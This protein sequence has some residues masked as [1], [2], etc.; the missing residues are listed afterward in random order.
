M[1]IGAMK[2]NAAEVLAAKIKNQ[3]GEYKMTNEN[4]DKKKT[5]FPDRAN[6]TPEQSKRL[7]AWVQQVNSA[8]QGALKISKSDLVNF[9]L[10]EKENELSDEQ[11]IQLEIKYYNEPRW[12]EWAMGQIKAAVQSD[13][14]VTLE[15]LL[16]ERNERWSR[17][18]NNN[19][20]AAKQAAKK[21]PKNETS[22]D[23]NGTSRIEV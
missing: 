10:A 3:T 5:A 19:S 21:R 17:F 20:N 13:A 1:A 6:L 9:F 8:S 23:N 2:L 16:N 18:K 22:H 11:I 15:G 14:T 12:I 7:E 4:I